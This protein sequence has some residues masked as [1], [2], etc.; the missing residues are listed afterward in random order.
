VVICTLYIYIMF[1]CSLLQVAIAMEASILR[2]D[3][4][5]TNFYNVML[6]SCDLTCHPCHSWC[7]A[8]RL[9]LNDTAGAQK[10]HSS[11]AITAK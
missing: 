1:M 5:P 2:F 9:S 8:C 6:Q 3:P 7:T 11:L 10:E 4:L